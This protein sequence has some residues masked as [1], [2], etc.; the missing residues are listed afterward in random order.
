MIYDVIKR[1]V[2]SQRLHWT[3]CRAVRSL[4]SGTRPRGLRILFCGS[5]DFSG[6]A[7]RKL[8][9]QHVQRQSDLIESLSVVVKA[10]KPSGRG[11]KQTR[12]VP[13]KELTK[14]L[15][16]TCH[17]I[18][19]FTG[20]DPPTSVNL[21]IAVSFGLRVPSRLLQQARYGGLNLHPSLLPD[22]S[23]PAPLHHALLL[24]RKTTGVTLQTLH[25]KHF[26]QGQIIAQ[27]AI[28]IPEN[29]ECTLKELHDYSAS[30]SADLLIDQITSGDFMYPE[31]HP[32]ALDHEL[33]H[34]RKVTPEDARVDW[35]GWTAERILRTQRVLGALWSI[36]TLPN[37]QSARVQW[38]GFRCVKVCPS[39]SQQFLR[40]GQPLLMDTAAG[41]GSQAAIWTIDR[42]C[43]SIETV[44][45][46][47]RR[48]HESATNGIRYL[49]QIGN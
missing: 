3:A 46:E 25:P 35:Q 29:G 12:D 21:I 30:V 23:G 34:A 8:H 44:T 10:G 40:A 1:R 39:S 7:L 18:E 24:G 17:E 37:G 22:L 36:F 9:E 41:P 19:T 42:R 11:L 28:D 48:K 43:L 38:H 2:L 13:I 47:G 33:T 4:S 32:A 14:R 26:D 31:Q 49:L 45:I 20:W 16:L 27:K 15:D 5:D 6:V